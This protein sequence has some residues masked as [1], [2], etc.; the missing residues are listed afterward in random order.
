M[1]DKLQL[2]TQMD[3][4]DS[5][6]QKIILSLLA[7]SDVTPVMSIPFFRSILKAQQKAFTLKMKR[8]NIKVPTVGNMIGRVHHNHKRY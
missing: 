2:L 1:K 7:F 5:F 3:L 6:M 8:L 4:G